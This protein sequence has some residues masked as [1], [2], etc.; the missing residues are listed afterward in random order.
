MNKVDD[1]LLDTN[2]EQDTEENNSPYPHPPPTTPLSPGTPVPLQTT[3]TGNDT[4]AP[5]TVAT[6]Q[7]PTGNNIPN[8]FLAMNKNGRG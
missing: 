2:M 8:Q 4:A 7:P 3:T 5:P 1:A 6:C